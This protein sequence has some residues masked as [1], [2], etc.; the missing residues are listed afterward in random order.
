MSVKG[1]VINGQTVKY[2][3]PDLDNIPSTP[4]GGGVSDDLKAALLQLAE[5]VAYI[6]ANGDDYYQDLYDALYSEPTYSVTNNLTEVTNSNAATRVTQGG[7]YSA[8]LTATSGYTINS[9]VVT[10]GGNDVTGT[11][12]SS[13]TI[14]IANVTGNIVITAVA[15]QRT[16]TLTSISAVFTQGQNVIYDTD[17]LDTLKQYLVVTAYYDDTSSEVLASSAYTLSGT[18]TTGTSTITA[19][20]GGKTDTFTV[21]VTHYTISAL[22]DWDFT[23]SLTDSSSGETAVLTGCTQ[24]SSGISFTANNQ[25]VQLTSQKVSIANKTFILD[26]SSFTGTFSGAYHARLFMSAE[27][28][29]TQT[30]AAGFAYRASYGWTVYTG[31]TWGTALDS[32]TY[33]FTFFNNKRLK[34]YVGSDL[35]LTISYADIGSDSFTEIGTLSSAIDS[36][37]STDYWIIG[38]TGNN[39]LKTMT[40]ASLKVYVGEV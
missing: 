1:F 40:L 38:G 3:Y 36:A 33:P 13:G 30:N 5:K 24:S 25:A 7:S 26:I 16:A 4:S 8:T 2:N 12:Y 29:N 32:T 28:T 18:L 20:Y 9:V 17:S 10:M 22:Y 6:D 19:S 11:V 23:S 37:Y 35:K 21:A 27:S 14:S 31:S 34:I 39:Q 15:T